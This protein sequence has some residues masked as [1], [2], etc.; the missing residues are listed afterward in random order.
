MGENK[1]CPRL[2]RVDEKRGDRACIPDFD[3]KLLRA[4]GFH[5]V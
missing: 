3:V 2:R 5:L 1:T 4:D